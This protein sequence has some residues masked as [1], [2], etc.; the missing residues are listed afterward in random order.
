M[1]HHGE[2]PDNLAQGDFERGKVGAL[3]RVAEESVEY[4]L[5]LGKVGLNFFGNLGDQQ[6]FLGLTR[7][8]VKLRYFRAGHGRIFGDAAMYPFDHD[9]DLMSKISAKP[10]EVFLRVLGE[11]DR[12]RNLHGQ[13]VGVACR[14]FRQPAGGRGDR[15]GEAT[16][17]RLSKQFD[18]V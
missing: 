9:V 17:I 2:R 5:D 11:Q 12:C 14:L 6:F 13:R 7:H 18:R 1:T 4:L 10:V 3:F 15:L 8:L 16:I